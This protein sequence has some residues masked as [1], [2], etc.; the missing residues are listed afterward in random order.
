[1]DAVTPSVTLTLNQ[2][3]RNNYSVLITFGVRSDDKD[4]CV[5]KLNVTKEIEPV[6]PETIAVDT[7][8]IKLEDDQEYCYTDRTSLPTEGILILRSLRKTT[9]NTLRQ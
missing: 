6:I 7:N 2:Y 3:C 5:G 8:V 9:I 1:M 4:T